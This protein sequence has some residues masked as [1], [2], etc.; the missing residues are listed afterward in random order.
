MFFLL[1][2][3]IRS[4]L[5]RFT[6]THYHNSA[7]LNDEKTLPRVSDQQLFS[8]RTSKKSRKMKSW[9]KWKNKKE[10][11]YKSSAVTGEKIC[12]RFIE[13]KSHTQLIS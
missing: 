6:N 2:F 10:K 5:L 9:Q 1:E 13:A 11:R 7:P 4:D 8:K 3:Q 12:L